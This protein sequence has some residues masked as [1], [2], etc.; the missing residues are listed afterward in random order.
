MSG[1]VHIE[2]DQI[3]SSASQFRTQVDTLVEQLGRIRGQLPS[4][5]SMCGNEPADHPSQRFAQVYTQHSEKMFTEAGYVADG[6]GK[7]ADALAKMAHDYETAD[8]NAQVQ[9]ND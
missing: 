6:L 5:S 8:Q 3:R 1:N 9:S 2:P 4:V 7:V